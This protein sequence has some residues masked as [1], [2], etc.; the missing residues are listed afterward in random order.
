MPPP[1]QRVW[2]TTEAGDVT[3]PLATETVVATLNGVSVPDPGSA[4]RLHGTAHV[5]TGVGATTITPRIR[6]TSLT[7]AL[8]GEADAIAVVASSIVAIVYDVDDL[9]GDVASLPY[10]L[11][12]T[13]AGVA[14][15]KNNSYLSAVVG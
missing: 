6:R 12:L 1:F 11:T 4:V 13:C 14:G 2:S 8:I 9:P 5:L 10:V 15:T 7:G 3:C